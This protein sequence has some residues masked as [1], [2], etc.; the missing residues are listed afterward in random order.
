MV[1]FKA[2][3]RCTL[4]AYAS[5]YVQR[6]IEHAYNTFT[7]IQGPMDEWIYTKYLLLTFFIT[8]KSN[9]HYV[10]FVNMYIVALK[11]HEPCNRSEECD[12]RKYQ[13]MCS[14]KY[15]ECLCKLSYYHRNR[16]CYRREYTTIF[17]WFFG[18][19]H[20]ILWT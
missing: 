6:E 10:L 17:M 19:S 9:Y 4:C 5:W 15:K 3:C 11:Y 1:V 8:L 13:L 2:L 20:V 18:P 12:G 7:I 16:K 14:T